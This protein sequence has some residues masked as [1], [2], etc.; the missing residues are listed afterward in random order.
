MSA[1]ISQLRT[2]LADDS[3]LLVTNPVNIRYLTG[4]TGSNGVV[5]ISHSQ[6]LLVTDSRYEL[7]AKLQV[8]DTEVSIAS[9]VLAAATAAVT[10]QTLNIE[11]RHM[12]VAQFQRV[13]NLGATVVPIHAAV[14]QLR[15][16]KDQGEVATIRQACEISAAALN[17]CVREGIAGKSE[18]SIARQLAH[19]MVNLGA[20]GIAFDSIVASGA[21]SA[22]PH[23]EPTDRVIQSGDLVKIDFGAMV[24]GYRSDCTRVLVVGS[25]QEWQR[26]MHGRAVVSH[27]AGL[28]HVAP[29]SPFSE[30]HNAAH[31]QLAGHE[32][33]FRHG[34]GHGVG[35][36]IHE[37]PMLSA[38]TGRLTRGHVI[39]V[40]PGVYVAGVGG[41][42]IEDT[43]LVTDQGHEVLTAYPYELQEI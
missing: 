28:D 21:N 6:A 7:Q 41:V 2:L 25:A 15:A 34:V 11:S 30:I 40:E 3:T 35:L 42:R 29:G 43:V 39:T 23:H 22:I 24:N 38:D 1:R 16:I 4:F 9:D 17:V 36:D 19:A 26:E 5:A 13:Q 10:T 33:A 20:D 12:T 31:A 27:H 8:V 14:E 18:R 32:G 37:A